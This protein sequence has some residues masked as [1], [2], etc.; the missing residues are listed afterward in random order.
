MLV[1]INLLPKKEHRKSSQFVIAI[2]ILLLLA[3]ASIAIYIQGSTYE[4]KMASVDKQI[5]SVQKQNTVHQEKLSGDEAGNSAIKLQSAV[6]WAEQYPMETVLLMQ[7]II[8]LLPERGFIQNFEYSNLNTVL[9]TI[10]YDASREAAYYLSALKQSE[11]VL[12]A[13]LLK[14]VAEK[15]EEE[16]EEPE[17]SEIG[18]SAE[19]ILPRYSAAYKI[20]FNPE[21]FKGSKSASEGGDES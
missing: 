2:S 16:A 1:D 10:Q 21:Y 11:W 8:A 3:A 20:T 15:M 17:S 12:E 5:E 6:Q 19:K 7:N 14:V 9:I 4:S 13:D 18:T